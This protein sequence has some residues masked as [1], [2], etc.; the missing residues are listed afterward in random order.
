[1]Y[2]LY[3][4]R[5]TLGF[6]ERVSTDNNKDLERRGKKLDEEGSS[7]S[8]PDAHVVTFVFWRTE[9]AREQAG[10]RKKRKVA[11]GEAGG[12][13]GGAGSDE[14]DDFGELDEEMDE[15]FESESEHEII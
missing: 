5:R 3:S 4:H 2:P 8:S 14:S 6:D 10:M 11:S 7:N 12:G 13:G 15:D 1:M 9:R